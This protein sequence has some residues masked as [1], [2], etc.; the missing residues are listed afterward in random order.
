M[1]ADLLAVDLTGAAHE[2]GETVP[3]TVTAYQVCSDRHLLRGSFLILVSNDA[4]GVRRARPS[5]DLPALWESVHEMS[6]AAR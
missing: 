1:R 6:I 3:C 4:C 5:R 2:T